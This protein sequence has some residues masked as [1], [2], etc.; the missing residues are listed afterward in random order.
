MELEPNDE[1]ERDGYR[2]AAFGVDHAGPSIGYALVEDP[3]PGQFDP[4]RARELGVEFGPDFG[5]L[6]RGEVV[7]GVQ[8]EQVMGE[9]RRGRKVVLTGDTA[10]SDM[11]RLVAWEAD[12]L[13]HEATFMEEEVERA[14][15]TRHSTAAQ[16]AELAAAAGV[17]MLALTHISPRYAGGEVRDEARARV[18][19]RDRAARLRPG[20]DPVPG[21]RRARAHP[22]VRPAAAARAGGAA[23]PDL[24]D[25]AALSER[26]AARVRGRDALDGGRRGAGALARIAEANQLRRAAV[27]EVLEHLLRELGIPALCAD[28]LAGEVGHTAEG[29]TRVLVERDVLAEKQRVAGL[30]KGVPFGS[31][32]RGVSVGG[33]HR[34]EPAI[35]LRTLW[36][37]WFHSS[38]HCTGC[39]PAWTDVGVR[40]RVL[41]SP[42]FL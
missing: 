20:R 40:P 33:D 26:T 19:E 35:C 32:E 3:R 18:R 16:A 29:L 15:E 22:R 6:Q 2:I 5:R 1:L 36:R 10:P 25:L 12:L 8:P 27:L 38:G 24:T 39:H 11:T 7:N 30:A 42:R 41:V 14:A 13:V 4:D 31:A 28:Q 17:Q 34:H 37:H 21:A 9:T 23:D